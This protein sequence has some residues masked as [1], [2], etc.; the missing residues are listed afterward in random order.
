[1]GLITCND[2]GAP[3]SDGAYFCPKCGAP[4][5]KVVAFRRR[6]RNVLIAIGVVLLTFLLLI[7][8]IF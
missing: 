8:L 6:V 4:P 3:V 7:L 1:M 5:P 2:C